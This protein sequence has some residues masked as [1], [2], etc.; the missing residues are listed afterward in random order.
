M[1]THSA[2]T[3]K[4]YAR[5]RRTGVGNIFLHVYVFTSSA[6]ILI[7]IRVYNNTCR[8]LQRCAVGEVRERERVPMYRHRSISNGITRKWHA[9]TYTR[10][11]QSPVVAEDQLKKH[12]LAKKKRNANLTSKPRNVMSSVSSREC[13]R[14]RSRIDIDRPLAHGTGQ[15][16][17]E[18]KHMLC[19]QR[20][21]TPKINSGTLSLALTQNPIWSECDECDAYMT[22]TTQI[23]SESNSLSIKWSN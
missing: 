19:V 12:V 9:A 6:H 10:Q 2:A 21:P 18:R 17:S 20:R 7:N 4:I 22:D 1:R 23:R 16:E 8:V 13:E 11:H 5:S 14:A 3:T 15:S